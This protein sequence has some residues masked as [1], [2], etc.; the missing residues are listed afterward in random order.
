MQFRRHGMWYSCPRCPWNFFHVQL[1]YNPL[2]QLVL[3]VI[4]RTLLQTFSCTCLWSRFIWMLGA[5]W[6]DASDG[7][8]QQPRF[9]YCM[10]EAMNVTPDGIHF[11]GRF[12]DV[13]RK[14]VGYNHKS[15]LVTMYNCTLVPQ[16][17]DGTIVP[18]CSTIY[19]AQQLMNA[20]PTIVHQITVRFHNFWGCVRHSTCHRFSVGEISK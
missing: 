15:W 2:V 18:E 6:L 7:R 5:L 12:Y 17:N 10:P 1:Y 14:S 9:R 11:Y 3:L 16:Q 4:L 8:Q 13:F 19:C 20:T